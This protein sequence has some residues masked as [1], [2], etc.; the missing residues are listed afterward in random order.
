MKKIA[1]TFI[2]FTLL[3]TTSCKD[4]EETVEPADEFANTSWQ[5]TL[6]DANPVT[7]PSG[8]F[9]ATGTNFYYPWASCNQDDIFSFKD[10]KF[11]HNNGGTVCDSD[12]LS[13]MLASKT[14]TYDKENNTIT[15][16]GFKIM[17]YEFSNTQLKLGFPNPIPSSG[18]KNYVI[19]LKKL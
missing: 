7:N 6:T 18:P 13:A 3:F 9:G 8:D 11:E 10:G 14:Y 4:K 15:I 1:L 2:S 16:G 19:L 17:V 5:P 12:Y